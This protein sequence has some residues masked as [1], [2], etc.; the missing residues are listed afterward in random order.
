MEANR[1][2]GREAAVGEGAP[3]AM[4]EGGIVCVGGRHRRMCRAAA[5]RGQVHHRLLGAQLAGCYL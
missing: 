5:A 3:V 1:G 4:V 2:P